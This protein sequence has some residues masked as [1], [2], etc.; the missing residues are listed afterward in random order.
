MSLRAAL[1]AA[2]SLPPIPSGWKT[3]A[4]IAK[5]EGLSEAR[6]RR[7]LYDA[8]KKGLYERQLWPQ[9]MISGVIRGA[10]IFRPTPAKK[11]ARR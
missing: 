10:P 1:S 2:E 9:R 3:T 11:P 7:L 6:C 5:A 8:L 4:Q